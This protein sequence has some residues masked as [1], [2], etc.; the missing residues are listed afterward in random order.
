MLG[1]ASG[2][3][4]TAAALLVG[5]VHSSLAGPNAGGTLILHANTN[6]TYSA[7]SSPSDGLVSESRAT[8]PAPASDRAV[9]FRTNLRGAKVHSGLVRAA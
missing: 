6:L 5:T 2:G 7:E 8:A 4:I 3:L 1:R 9:A